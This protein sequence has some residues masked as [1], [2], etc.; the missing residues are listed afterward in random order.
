MGQNV[1]PF[2]LLTNV[3]FY[4]AKNAL[5][6]NLSEIKPI[7]ENLKTSFG[8]LG[9]DKMCVD[10]AGNMFITNDGLQMN[11]ID[12]LEMEQPV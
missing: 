3:K 11:K 2:S 7:Y 12:Q 4:A 8:P 9:L 10:N 5:K 6:K 1:N